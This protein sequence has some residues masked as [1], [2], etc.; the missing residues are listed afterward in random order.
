MFAAATLPA[1]TARITVAGPGLSF[2]RGGGGSVAVTDTTHRP[3]PVVHLGSASAG[4]R[5][6]NL[7]FT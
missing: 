1:A 7:E 5:F 2:T 6:K 3:V 4:V